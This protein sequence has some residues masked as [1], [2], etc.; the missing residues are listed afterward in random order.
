[1]DLETL[2]VRRLPSLTGAD[3]NHPHFADKMDTGD[4][5]MPRS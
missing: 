4:C 2:G 5:S 3:V 1:M